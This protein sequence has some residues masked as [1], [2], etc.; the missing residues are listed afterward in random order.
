MFERDKEGN[1]FNNLDWVVIL[2]YLALVL[3]G[4][5]NI[6]SAEYDPNNPGIFNFSENYG[7]Q[8]IWICAS[9]V[10]AI[11]IL[12]VDARFYS[13]FA[14]GFY[15]IVLALLVATLL[16]GKEVAGARSWLEIGGFGLQASE[17]AK[18]ATS[19]AVAKYLNRYEVRVTNVKHAAIALLLIAIPSVLILMQN[20]TGSALV[21][22]AFV[23][24][25][26]RQG[27]PGYFLYLPV[28]FGVL[29]LSVLLFEKILVIITLAGLAIL[30]YWLIKSQKR[31]LL[32]TIAG[33]VVAVGFVFAVDYTFNNVLQP[34]Q[35][36]R[37]NVLLGKE[38]DTKG[39]GYNVHQ[40][41]IAIGAGGLDG[42]GFLDGTQ[43]KFNFVPEQS[44]DFIFCTIGEEY[45]FIGS[46]I[47]IVLFT[48][49][50]IHLVFS[51]ESQKARFPRI[52]AYGVISIILLHITINIGM[53]MGLLP[54]IG[55]P[56]PFISYG[57]SSL[58]GFTALLFIYLKLDA[59]QKRFYH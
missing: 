18:F 55:I 50:L 12:I 15:L 11:I 3:F 4:W 25:L 51:A 30:V 47:L 29:F 58:F 37:I 34:H 6:Y 26:F 13:A 56:L 38:I 19:L 53:T 52:Y 42:K 57:G 17:F 32:I 1:I 54:V 24:V 35:Q 44:T 8:F 10:L 22:G 20:D 46:T 39:A 5:I 14:Y 45:G 28:G 27:L 49:L 7:K 59:S 33:L 21:Y 9:V 23:L 36:Q 41:L 48:Y 43:T 40:S 31:A 2:I 16:F